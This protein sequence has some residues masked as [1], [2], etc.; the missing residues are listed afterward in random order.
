MNELLQNE[1]NEK[2]I[3]KQ[4]EATDIQTANEVEST[5][6]QVVTFKCQNFDIYEI[7]LPL[8]KQSEKRAKVSNSEI[9]NNSFICLNW[10]YLG[11]L[12]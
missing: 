4:F 7:Q 3:D 12:L 9:N 1:N 5:L 2:K 6:K 10:S 8:Q 11:S